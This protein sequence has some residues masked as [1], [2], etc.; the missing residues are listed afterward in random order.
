[1]SKLSA[2]L[3]QARVEVDSRLRQLK[4][5]IERSGTEIIAVERFDIGVQVSPGQGRSGA[6][7]IRVDHQ[8]LFEQTPRVIERRFRASVL[9]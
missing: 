2:S 1:M 3:R 7:V 8:A 5:A 6:R 4:G 9:M